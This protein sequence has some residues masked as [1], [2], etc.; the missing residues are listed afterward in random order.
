MWRFIATCFALLALA[1]YLLSGGASYTPAPGSLQAVQAARESGTPQARTAP[2]RPAAPSRSLAEVEATMDELRH[3]EAR[4]EELSVTLA[5]TRRDAAG[6]IEAEASRPKAEL[7]GLQLPESIGRIGIADNSETREEDIEAALASALGQPD[8]A[9][10]Q[11]RWVKENTVDLRT[12]PGLSFDTVT[13]I[14]KGTEV[15]VLEDPGHGW[16]KVRVTG[17]YQSGWVAEWLLVDPD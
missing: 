1:F 5:S 9:P 13:L 11:L 15:A 6:I 17:G 12:G 14:T 8:F 7:L 2:E 16:L 10:A 3:A 4:T